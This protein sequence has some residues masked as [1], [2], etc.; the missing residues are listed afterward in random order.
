[1]DSIQDNDK[2]LETP[3]AEITP[4][5][6]AKCSYFWPEFIDRGAFVTSVLHMCEYKIALECGSFEEAEALVAELN[7]QN[8]VCPE[9]GSVSKF[10]AET[11]FEILEAIRMTKV[12]NLSS[13]Q[14]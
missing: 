14:R 6:Y 13:S 4:E 10:K 11:E 9:C 2:S 7:G 12:I 5:F 8:K 3:C 1:M